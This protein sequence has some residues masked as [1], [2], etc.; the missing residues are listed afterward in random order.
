MKLSFKDSFSPA[1]LIKS[2]AVIHLLKKKNVTSSCTAKAPNFW[3]KEGSVFAYNGFE[4]QYS[5]S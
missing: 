1:V 5:I 4:F 2:N 3:Q